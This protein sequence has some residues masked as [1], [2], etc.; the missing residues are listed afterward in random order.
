MVGIVLLET[1]NR[2][3]YKFNKFLFL[4]DH[5]QICRFLGTWYRKKTQR[6]FKT[7]ES[8]N[9]LFYYAINFHKPVI[10]QRL[11]FV[12]FTVAMHKDLLVVDLVLLVFEG[13]L[14][15]ASTLIPATNDLLAAS[16]ITSDGVTISAF[17]P[18]TFI[19]LFTFFTACFCISCV[20]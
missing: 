2:L 9:K 10:K 15:H 19:F 13:P 16:V 14:G 18:T 12:C 6:I 4:L 7:T 20:T 8:K 17:L 1:S 11:I 3:Y 5:L